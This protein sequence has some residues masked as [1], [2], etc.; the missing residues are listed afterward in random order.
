MKRA[1]TIA[2]YKELK[3]DC[4]VPK[5]YDSNLPLGRWVIRQRVDYNRSLNGG[6]S[7]INTERIRK[8]DEIGFIWSTR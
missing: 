6:K 7:Y 2:S 1:G 5:K 3:G 4:L 8:L